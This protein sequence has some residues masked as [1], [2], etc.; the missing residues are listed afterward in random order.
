MYRIRTEVTISAAHKLNLDYDSPCSNLHGHN[1][2]ITIWMKSENLL[3]NGMVLD[4][5]FIKK[6]IKEKFDHKTLNNLIPQPTAENIARYIFDLLNNV[7][8][9]I[10]EKVE[11]QETEGNYASYEV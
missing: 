6:L 3:E 9:P 5:T 4:F 11:V 8:T 2:K 1:W 10:C 7:Y